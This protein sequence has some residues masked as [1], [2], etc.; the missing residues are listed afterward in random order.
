MATWQETASTIRNRWATLVETPQS[1]PTEYDNAP[2][3]KP[4]DSQWA[5]LTVLP[6]DSFQMELG[7]ASPHKSVGL[8]VAQIFVPSNSGT[9]AAMLLVVAAAAEFKAQVVSGVTFR[10][11]SVRRVG[12]SGM[13]WQVNLSMPYYTED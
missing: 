9:R 6:G 1:L 13:W 5:R 11:P 2:F 12:L 8:A 7:S 4:D 3:D 10:S